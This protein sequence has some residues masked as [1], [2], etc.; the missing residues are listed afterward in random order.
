MDLK[1]EYYNLLEDIID[2]FKTGFRQRKGFR[3]GKVSN[4]SEGEVIQNRIKEGG[5]SRREVFNIIDGEIIH[6][7]RCK[8]HLNRINAVPGDGSID[9]DIF[10]IGEGPGEMEDIKG[11]PFVG[12]AG[13]LLTRMLSAINLKREE[14]YIT[15]IVKCRPPNN[16]TPE[17][18]E[19]KT[20]FPYLERQIEVI[21]P[22]ILCCLGGPAIKVLTGRDEGISKL[23]GTFYRYKDIPVLPT[24]HPAA[25]LRFPDKYKRASWN[26]LKMLRDFYRDVKAKSRD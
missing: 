14:V 15:N 21:S 20:C 1:R 26:D 6:C 24:F 11:K 16:R 17:P 5:P 12:R 7:T 9:A 3:Q 18:E 13:E 2:Y 10:F 23:R 22:I 19:I 4:Y 8:L 25:I